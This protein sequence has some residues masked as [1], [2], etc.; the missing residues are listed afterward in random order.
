MRG[1]LGGLPLLAGIAE[2]TSTLF[3]GGTIIG[4][5]NDTNS[6]E[7]FRNGSLLVEGDRIA[8]IH[9]DAGSPE[10]AGEGVVVIDVSGQILTPGMI[11]TH[12]HG[13]QTGFKTLGSNTTLAEYFHRYSSPAS[14]MD[15]TEE[16]VYIGQLAGIYEALNAGV[17]TIV[18]HAHH[19]WTDETS[20]A[21]LK[22][23][24][25]S[26][27]R[28]FWCYAFENTTNAD[29]PRTVTEQIAN[30]REVYATD[31]WKRS[32]TEIGVAYDSW[33]PQPDPAERRAILDLAE[34]YD[35]PVI[36]THSLGGPWGITNM[37]SD[38]A[39]LD[40]LE[41]DIPFIFS[42]ASF[43]SSND[44]GLL[45]Q[46]NHYV[47]ITPESEMHYGHTHAPS[48]LIQDQAAL[49]V[50]THFTFSTDILIQARLWLQ[51][52]RYR[53]F[54]RLVVDRWEL[55][56]NTPETVKQAFLLATRSGGLSLRRNDLGVLNV[57]AKADLLVWNARESPALLGW[58]DPIAAVMLHAS[59]G[60]IKDVMVDGKF[61][62]RNG[63]LT[64]DGY[65]EVRER[66]LKSAKS[67]QEK[68]AAKPY[69]VIEGPW[70]VGDARYGDT[71]RTDVVRGEGDG[72]GDLFVE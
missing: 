24:A 16:D 71:E 28:V 1:V 6:L 17:T 68:W 48:Y 62:K 12:R 10:D 32:P 21:G 4:F 5:N 29:G 67:L 39:G 11:D 54:S 34:E 7:V 66:F 47:S 18:D 69:P 2:A 64:V 70:L 57:G 61:V 22:A 35:V 19:T 33:G 52:T 30:F 25:E 60:D 13:W 38:L 45:R 42:H 55:P 36:T 37:P 44:A 15:I 63:K 51:S 72:Y 20:I 56:R 46:N 27:A 43:L 8:A 59:V 23:S 14:G 9:E 49:G 26:G 31:D 65:D 3:W 40:A 50:D 41:G 58:N 53:L